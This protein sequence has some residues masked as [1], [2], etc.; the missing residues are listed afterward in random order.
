MRAQIDRV[1]SVHRSR[2]RVLFAQVPSHQ[3]AAS[4]QDVLSSSRISHERTHHD[5]FSQE[6]TCDGTPEHP[7][8]ADDENSHALV[9]P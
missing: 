7:S 4:R 2:Y 1:D 5:P 3:L 6:A 9:Q 8:T